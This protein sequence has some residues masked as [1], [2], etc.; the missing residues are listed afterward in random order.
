MLATDEKTVQEPP[1]AGKL[2]K[3]M[4]YGRMCQDADGHLFAL[5]FTALNFL[6]SVQLSLLSQL[7][8]FGSVGSASF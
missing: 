2:T 6:L 5:G 8:S 4:L 7:M 3:R 1:K